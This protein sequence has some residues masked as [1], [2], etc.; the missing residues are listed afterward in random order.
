MGTN[1]L[2]MMVLLVIL[3]AGGAVAQ[4]RLQTT[5][6][7][8][9]GTYHDG[10]GV[11]EFKGIPYAEPPVGEW[12]WRAPRPVSRWNGVRTT[13]RFGAACVQ[14]VAGSRLPWSQEFL[15]REEISEDCLFLN[16]WTGA[17]SAREWRPVL[18][19]IHG[20]GYQEGSG[21]VD[22]YNGSH[23]ARRGLVVVTIN[24][25]LG[26]FGYLA[27]PELTAESKLKTSGNYG[28]LDQLEALR[29]VK[30]NIAAFG[31]DPSR[32]TIAGQSAGASSVHNL[33]ASPLAKGLFQRA[34]AQSGSSISGLVT[35]AL[36]EAEKAGQ[37]L[38]KAR[39]AA[40]LRDLRA[41][42]PEQLMAGGAPS[43][44]FAPVVDGWALPGDALA[45][46][47][48]GHHHDL[49]VLTGLN[50]DEASSQPTYG[51]LSA[52]D[53]KKQAVERYGARAADFLRLYPAMTDAEAS[54][55]QKDASRDRNCVSMHLWATRRA[56]TSRTPAWTYYF[57]RAIPWPPYPQYGAFH[58][59][60]VPYVFG[61]TG[62]LDR[63]WQPKDHE[64]SQL[65]M[66]YWINFASSG[67]PN[68]PGLPAWPAF[69]PGRDT[70]FEIGENTG[71][72]SITTPERRRFF[73]DYLQSPQLIR[74]S[75]LF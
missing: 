47:A 25:R 40:T 69:D 8:I 23:L 66:A 68:G 17:N 57:T 46:I 67:N 12:R 45:A 39:G 74:G 29:W 32:V 64:V 51:R 75:I 21:A 73:T 53:L 2:R 44:R 56:R 22:V 70:T 7:M 24:Y 26:V 37:A 52:D 55:S 11:R 61:T 14:R 71:V 41:M 59:G 60:E 6:G 38:A 15:V 30:R 58:T 31:G 16:V 10:T 63:P 5:G 42:T 54:I 49:P 4:T 34:I 62:W 20:G 35:P 3:L 72:R 28:M 65:M 50:A 27:H 43:T 19:Y 48:A 33:I 36:V 13:Q 9:E 18:V 1:G